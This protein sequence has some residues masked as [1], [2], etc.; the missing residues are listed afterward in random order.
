[1]IVALVIW[2]MSKFGVHVSEERIAELDREFYDRPALA[3]VRFGKQFSHG[4]DRKTAFGIGF[5]RHL[6]AQRYV[7][8][9]LHADVFG[10][11]K[12]K[13]GDLTDFQLGAQLYVHPVKP[14]ELSYSIGPLWED[15]RRRL[16]NRFGAG[17]R[18]STMHVA[19]VPT[20]WVDIVGRKPRWQVG[21]QIEF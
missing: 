15:G 14:L 21:C 1:M 4:G 3:N 12:H 8:L 9:G 18:M 10:S 11:R 19:P 17:Y 7:A 5:E 16:F 6:G 2:M 20:L 13:D